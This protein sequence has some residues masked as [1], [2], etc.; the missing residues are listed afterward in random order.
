MGWWEVVLKNLDVG[1]ILLTPGR[2]LQGSRRK[3][4]KIVLKSPSTINIASGNSV[5]PLERLCFDAIQEAYSE[6]PLLWLRGAS[7]HDNEPFENSLD[8]LV[9]EATGS[10]L[11]RGNYICSILEHC[12]LVRYTMRGNKKG[13]EAA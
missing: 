5:V 11:A 1:D 2:G 7:L 12:G 10:Q 4:F 9:R 3:P 13:I 8:K 6:N